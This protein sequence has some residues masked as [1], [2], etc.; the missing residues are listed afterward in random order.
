MQS[1]VW[2]PHG[3]QFRQEKA[4]CLCRTMNTLSAK[5]KYLETLL[6]IGGLLL[7][8]VA[9][10]VYLGGQIYSRLAIE[11]FHSQLQN[12]APPAQSAAQVDDS[13]SSPE[14]TARNT[15]LLTSHFQ[16][17][18]ALLKI[19][20]LG[21]EV[22][23]F[24]GTGRSALNRG[25]GT[26]P[27]T[28]KI[29]ESGN[30]GIAGHRDGFFRG[31]SAVSIGDAITLETSTGIQVYKIDSIVVVERNDVSVL[32]NESAPGLTLVTCFPFYIVGNAPQRYIVH[33]TL[34]TEARAAK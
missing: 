17:P 4:A 11:T 23:V 21:L 20:K 27:G 29:G 19:E 28:A 15:S 18:L 5:L 26:I 10:S 2:A 34:Q 25:V 9:V 8:G 31:L 7:T 12:Q 13:R 22:P 16:S 30:I 6:L 24:E 3:D 32:K 33:S 1:H 14:R